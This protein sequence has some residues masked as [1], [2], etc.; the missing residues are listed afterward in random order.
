M[1]Q[2]SFKLNGIIMKHSTET[3]NGLIFK[4]ISLKCADSEEVND[5][6]EALV[7]WGTTADAIT[8]LTHIRNVDDE[9]CSMRVIPLDEYGICLNMTIEGED[10]PVQ[11]K[12]IKVARKVKKEKDFDG[13]VRRVKFLEATLTLE[14][15]E[16]DTDTR[17][18]YL[19]LKHTKPN[20]K[21]KEVLSP[22]EIQFKQI[23]PFSLFDN[24]KPEE[25]DSDDSDE[26]PPVYQN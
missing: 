3:N 9:P 21:G 13:E 17:F 14:K 18:N 16:L 23:E 10:T 5:L 15:K 26:M 20:D 6:L 4:R 22:L 24:P 19:F 2:L 7:A 11:F 8:N 1:S 25:D 12:A